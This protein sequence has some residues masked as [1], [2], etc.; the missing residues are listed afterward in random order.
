VTPRPRARP[1]AIAGAAAVGALVVTVVVR[2]ATSGDGRAPDPG[3]EAVGRGARPAVAADV[4]ETPA[5]RLDAGGVSAPLGA[6]VP[7]PTPTT[8]AVAVATRA[9]ASPSPST[10]PTAARV[11]PTALPAAPPAPRAGPSTPRATPAPSA[12]R[13]APAGPAPSATRAPTPTPSEAPR[14]PETHAAAPPRRGVLALRIGGSFADVRVDGQ[15]TA[16]NVYAHRL[17]LEPGRHEITVEKPGFGRHA[18]IRVEVLADGRVL[19]V[20]REGA[21][22][23]IA[24]LSFLI[25][26]AGDAAPLGWIPER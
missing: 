21:P 11:A 2:A 4:G 7:S 15:V 10:T 1:A 25:P 3:G 18:A 17:D 13:A 14:G 6:P 26:R 23:P 8:D 5:A 9:P 16:R 22:R 20:V 24:E 19:E 12:V